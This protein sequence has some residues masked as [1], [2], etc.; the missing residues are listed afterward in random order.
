MRFQVLELL[1]LSLPS[2]ESQVSF[3]SFVALDT[4]LMLG[5]RFRELAHLDTY[6][7]HHEHCAT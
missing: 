3:L 2:M 5:S 4:Q 6:Q 7:I 1:M